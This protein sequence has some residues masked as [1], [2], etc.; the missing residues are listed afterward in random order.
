M[1]GIFLLALSSKIRNKRILLTALTLCSIPI[2]LGAG[3]A[4]SSRVQAI[5]ENF[6]PWQRNEPTDYLDLLVKELSGVPELAGEDAYRR[7]GAE[8]REVMKQAIPPVDCAEDW[9]QVFEDDRGLICR[10]Y[11]VRDDHAIE[12]LQFSNVSP[13]FPPEPR[14]NHPVWPV[15]DPKLTFLGE[16]TDIVLIEKSSRD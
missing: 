10:V 7:I 6:S 9:Y 2:V 8:V 13:C 5:D 15:P 1:T 12:P 16:P 14:T 11:D 4:Y 3:I